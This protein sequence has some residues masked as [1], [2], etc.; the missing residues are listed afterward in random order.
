MRTFRLFVLCFSLSASGLAFLPG[1]EENKKKKD[2]KKGEP[3]RTQEEVEKSRQKLLPFEKV[4]WLIQNSKEAAAQPV[5][6]VRL[7]AKM[8]L[9]NDAKKPM[10]RVDLTISYDGPRFPLHILRPSFGPYSYG[11]TKLAIHLIDHKEENHIVIVHPPVPPPVGIP[12]AAIGR[13]TFLTLQKNEIGK[14]TFEVS[15][16][17]VEDQA[18]R[19]HP[20]LFQDSAPILWLAELYHFPEDRGEI[21][22]LDAWTG[23]IRS[24]LLVV[25][26]EKV[27]RK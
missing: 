6:G 14:G 4:H 16:Q 8:E 25:P 2:V 7:R 22:S 26:L 12:G 3:D 21:H 5:N 15:V 9:K 27:I 18:R 13:S 1:G 10:I 17:E 24:E 11:Q 19:K 20:K 23:L